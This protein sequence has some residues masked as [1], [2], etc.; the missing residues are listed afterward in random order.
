MNFDMKKI[1]LL[2]SIFLVVL[3]SVSFAPNT[4]YNVT[5]R[6]TYSNGTGV[7][8]TNI[9]MY[10]DNG[11]GTLIDIGNSTTSNN[12]GDYTVRFNTTSPFNSFQIVFKLRNSTSSAITHMGP[13][14]PQFPAQM[15]A[16][17]FSQ[18]NVTL[19]PATTLYINATRRYNNTNSTETMVNFSGSLVDSKYGFMITNFFPTQ[20]GGDTTTNISVDILSGRN[21]TLSVMKMGNYQAG[22][23]G[24]APRSISVTNTNLTINVNSNNT[25]GLTLNLTDIPVEITGNFTIN[26]TGIDPNNNQVNI[27]SIILYPYSNGKVMLGSFGGINLLSFGNQPGGQDFG[28]WVR[29]TNNSGSS[30][31]NM[32]V[33]GTSTGMDYLMA[34]YGYNG[35]PNLDSSNRYFAAFQ[36]ITVTNNNMTNFNLT[37]YELGGSFTGTTSP[38]DVNGSRFI[39]T[40]KNNDTTNA[41]TRNIGSAS[42]EGEINYSSANGYDVGPNSGPN[43]H[44][45]VAI[46]FVATSNGSGSSAIPVLTNAKF[47]IRI[48]NQQFAPVKKKLNASSNSTTIEMTGQSFRKPNSTESYSAISMM[49]L[50]SNSTCNVQEPDLRSDTSGGCLISNFTAGSEG[51]F[52]PMKMMMS[53]GLVNIMVKDPATGVTGLFIG[54]DLFASGPPD[55]QMPSAA[56]SS[57]TAGS[58]LSQTWKFGSTAPEVFQYAYVGIPYSDSTLDESGTTKVLLSNVYDEDWNSQWTSSQGTG[59]VP[60]DFADYNQSFFNQSSGGIECTTNT[61]NDCHINKTTN[62][63]WLKMPHFSGSDP[64][65][66]GASFA[67]SGSSPSS[68]DSNKGSLQIVINNMICPGDKVDI[69]VN[70]RYST[71]I[72]D[73]YTRLIIY[74]PYLGEIASKLTDTNGNVVFSLPK[75]ATYQVYADK[76]SYNPNDKKFLFDGCP[77]SVENNGNE[78]NNMTIT[79][80]TII[81]DNR[82][83]EKTP[84]TVNV[85]EEQ[86]TNATIAINNAD[87]EIT[88]MANEGKDVSAARSKLEEANSA[89]AAGNYEQAATLANEAKSLASTAQPLPKVEPPKNATVAPKKTTEQPATPKQEFPVIPVIVVIVII[90]LIAAYF[91]FMNKG[92]SSEG[93]KKT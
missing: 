8:N 31:Y 41:F 70:D 58:S 75:T 59:A 48:F 20:Q 4:I 91:L 40:L 27:S 66:S 88:A 44:G 85:T 65:I 12:S 1:L 10:M 78:S 69:N 73:V 6:I 30:G 50:T 63:I 47:N 92:D 82:G 9:S 79:N 76:I 5:G 18:M 26:A 22:E 74:E 24:A 23:K 32:T 46:K 68:G 83:N 52:N 57:T 81:T 33:M 77:T 34:V 64:Q 43:G 56:T 90:G 14:L 62:K 55:M 45:A 16:E 84:T 87:S 21:Y 89:F 2:F 67:S 36:N 25:Y 35:S 61:G 72:S 11:M 93:Y 37:L 54:T 39:L 3:T 28:G 51:N 86:K 38:M 60:T 29:S 13:T 42:A 49:F 15:F 17:R 71:G 80:T 19:Y 7:N 53:G